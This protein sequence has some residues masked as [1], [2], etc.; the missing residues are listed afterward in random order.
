MRKSR[1]WVLSRWVSQ[2]YEYTKKEKTNTKNR[3]KKDATKYTNQPKHVY[4]EHSH[5][6]TET[7]EVSMKIS[8]VTFSIYLICCIHAFSFFKYDFIFYCLEI[9]IFID[10]F[11]NGLS[12]RYSW[13]R[14]FIKYIKKLFYFE[15]LKLCCNLKIY[16]TWPRNENIEKS[17][18]F[19][20]N[21]HI[22]ILFWDHMM[23]MNY[24]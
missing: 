6:N 4:K 18:Y 1:I 22:Q 21:L 15:Q 10:W 11:C 2:A 19:V 13:W 14:T 12:T 7:N 9:E 24:W 20:K 5:E 8:F 3:N 17:N 23:N 16:F